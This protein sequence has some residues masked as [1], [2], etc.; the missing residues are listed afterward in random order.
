MSSRA[1]GS[2][3]LSRVAREG[4][5]EIELS[6]LLPEGA[7]AEVDSGALFVGVNVCASKGGVFVFGICTVRGDG[8]D[9]ADA[10][11]AG[12]P[13]VCGVHS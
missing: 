13:L 11:A 6:A 5:D 9:A 3:E 1:F 12:E 4:V 7:A 10:S 8:V 2:S